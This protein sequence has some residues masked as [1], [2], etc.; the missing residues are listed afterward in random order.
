MLVQLEGKVKVCLSF[1]KVLTW[2][3]AF[4]STVGKVTVVVPQQEMIVLAP[5]WDPEMKLKEKTGGHQE[6]W[7]AVLLKE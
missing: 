5:T 6:A 1:E 7:N 3:D 2:E 4:A